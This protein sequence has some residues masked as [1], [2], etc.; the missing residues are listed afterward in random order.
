MTEPL[1]LDAL[2]RN[3]MAGELPDLD[4]MVRLFAAARRCR[5]L[6]SMRT[7]LMHEAEDPYQQAIEL[8]WDPKA[9]D[10]G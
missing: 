3:Y 9:K 6:E 8:G 1:D 10:G 5:E 4:D 7:F 2:E